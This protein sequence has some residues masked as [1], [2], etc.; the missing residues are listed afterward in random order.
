M[1][2]IVSRRLSVPLED[3]ER[4]LSK[5]EGLAY[6][7]LQ[8]VKTNLDYLIEMGFSNEDIFRSVQILL[9]PKYVSK[10]SSYYYWAFTSNFHVE[11]NLGRICFQT[12][13]R[14]PTQ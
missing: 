12:F 9:Y 4:E 11:I 6:V 8:T 5:N 10:V 7:P 13:G 14:K 2:L 3:V 1:S